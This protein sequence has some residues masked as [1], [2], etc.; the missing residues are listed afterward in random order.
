M[1][2][3]L[4]P[5]A[6]VMLLR[7]IQAGGP[8]NPLTDPA[9]DNKSVAETLAKKVIRSGFADFQDGRMKAK[10]ITREEYED[11]RARADES[12]LRE[13]V[14]GPKATR[15]PYPHLGMKR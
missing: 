13:S 6:C 11:V 12:P 7:C 4:T 15:K 3:V 10:S 2:D 1:T 8:Y 14:L 9:W 5:G